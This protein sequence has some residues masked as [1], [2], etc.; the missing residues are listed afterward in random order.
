M[1]MQVCVRLSAM[2]AAVVT[3]ALLGAAP[4]LGADIGLRVLSNRADLVSGD[5]A[6]IEVTAP[7]GTSDSDLTLDVGGRAVPAAFTP[8]PGGRLVGLVDGLH[9][10]VNVLTARA[11]DGSTSRLTITDNPIG[12]KTISGE[13][14]QPRL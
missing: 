10:G 11:P 9:L 5:D 8:Q 4:A 12:G 6:L 13:Q 14:V 7:A 3:T 1:S 2:A